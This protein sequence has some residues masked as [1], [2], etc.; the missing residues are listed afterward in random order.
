MSSVYPSYEGMQSLPCQ[1][2]HAPLL[3]NE[4]TCRNCGY[5][6]A[7]AQG[8]N[9]AVPS[10]ANGGW[11]GATPQSP[12]GQ[13]QSQYGNSSWGQYSVPPTS[14]PANQ[15][16]QAQN[17][18]NNPPS[19]PGS[20]NF[21]GAPV[22][23]APPMEGNG[24]A[25]NQSAPPFAPQ[26]PSGTFSTDPIGPQSF[27]PPSTGSLAPASYG[28]PS[29]GPASQAPYGAPSMGPASQ[30]PYGMAP[31]GFQQFGVPTVSGQSYPGMGAFD[32][33]RTQS[34]GPQSFPMGMAAPQ[35]SPELPGFAQPAM[36]ETPSAHRTKP[37]MIVLI[38]LLV[39][40]LI[41]G[42]G[43][44]GYTLLN[45]QHSATVTP[46]AVTTG[47][48]KGALLFSDTF[49]NNAS[50]WSL[51]A[52][53]GKFSISLANG[54]L[55]IEDDS[56]EL[57]WEPLPGN[58]TY[59]DF[60]L[61]VDAMLSRGDLT[62]GYGFY[63]RGSSVQNSEMATYYRFELYG[64]GSYAIFKGVADANGNPTSAKLVNYTLSS[65]IQKQGIINHISITA[66]GS[67]L[68]LTVNGQVVK[69][70]TDTSYANGS[71]APFISNMQ[72]AKP[73]AQAKFSNLV[74]NAA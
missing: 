25:S 11:N 45:K 23:S 26:R 73:G 48:A 37:W 13:D 41:G 31:A 38:V 50:G 18:F 55:V 4:A 5:Y 35:S 49:K 43:F 32:A 19:M 22:T 1:R 66:K 27:A 67:S 46:A 44:F 58:K 20:R 74:I 9:P 52:D 64:D 15:S 59:S 57:L 6:N 30:A 60:T 42:G 17:A 12:N 8:N 54:S 56:N 39:L 71:I 65:A 63:I 16:P 36:Q 34:A 61:S 29:T 47:A 28:A 14:A 70:L 72:N 68:S 51:Q 53:P 69:T 21:F 24:Y 10:F 62:N 33:S 3:P 40:V 2:C 7:P